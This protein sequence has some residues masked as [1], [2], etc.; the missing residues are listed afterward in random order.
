M[1]SQLYPLNPHLPPYSLFFFFAAKL[2]SL[3]LVQALAYC[4]HTLRFLSLRHVDHLLNDAA[5][6][7]MLDALSTCTSNNGDSADNNNNN[8][9]NNTARPSL[10]PYYFSSYTPGLLSLNLGTSTRWMGKNLRLTDRSLYLITASCKNLE[11][12][13]LQNQDGLTDEGMYRLGEGGL[14]LKKLELSLCC[15][16]TDNGIMSL[17]SS[18]EVLELKN[19]WRVTGASIS[20]LFQRANNLRSLN[21][22]GCAF[23][24][25]EIFRINNNSNNTLLTEV[26]L[27]RVNRMRDED[28]R[29]L[30]KAAGKSLK[31]VRWNVYIFVY[32]IYSSIGRLIWSQVIP[33]YK[34]D[35]Y[36][37]IKVLMMMHPSFQNNSSTRLSIHTSLILAPIHP[38]ISSYIHFT[39]FL[40][41]LGVPG[42]LW[43]NHQRRHSRPMPP[44]WLRIS[45]R[46]WLPRDRYQLYPFLSRTGHQKT[47]IKDSVKL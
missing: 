39:P 40:L 43:L 6:E 45:E 4:K 41:V 21:L 20:H 24:T 10:L 8:N 13:Y 1:F 44:L 11:C 22:S 29:L 3:I 30:Y 31:Q 9:K 12:L 42:S 46:G 19:C 36:I 7:Q 16:I 18:L 23:L 28:V 35:L 5:L 38:S 27:S 26:H 34:W 14:K 17:P 15:K 33:L 25:G 37:H 2:D 32:I 47:T